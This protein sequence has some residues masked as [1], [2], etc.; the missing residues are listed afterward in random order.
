MDGQRAGGHAVVVGA[1]MAGLSAATVLARRFRRVTIIER[2]QLDGTGNARRGVPQG[3]HAHA[4][5]A[6]GRYALER[7]HP[8]V[9]D[10]L[11]ESGALRVNSA[12]NAI[13]YQCGGRRVRY[14]SGVEGICLS[15]PLLEAVIRRRTLALPTVEL[16]AGGRVEELILAG[17]GIAGVTVERSGDRQ[18]IPAELVVDASGRPAP[19]LGPLGRAGFET[20]PTSEVHVDLAYAS[21]EI[22]RRP[23]DLGGADYLVALASTPSSRGAFVLPIEGDR[24]IVTLSGAHGDRPSSDATGFVDF[25]RSLPTRELAE[26]VERAPQEPATTYR[27]ASSQ[28]RHVERLR[29]PPS[30]YLLIGDAVCSFNPVYG[31]GMTSAALQAEVLGRELDRYGAVGPRLPRRFYRRVASVIE[32][33]WRIA[34]GTDFALPATSGPKPLGTGLVNRYMGRVL[35]ACHR[36]PAITEQMTR[37]QNLLDPPT[38]LLRPDRVVHVLSTRKPDRPHSTS[39]TRVEVDR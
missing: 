2:D 22:E 18:D 36:S 11:V 7:L 25:A 1:S 39:P 17:D 3:R 38:S 33:P 27:M 14:E 37:V 19:L 15:R 10:E 24:W 9:I 12:G 28:R 20:P 35:E 4:L 29:R 26:L 8:G 34:V 30:G 31:Q 5:L 13:W 6:A 23:G 32:N 21:R 16:L